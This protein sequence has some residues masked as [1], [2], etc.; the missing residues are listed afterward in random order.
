MRS[1]ED[2]YLAASAYT[3]GCSS[4]GKV[5]TTCFGKTHVEERLGWFMIIQVADIGLIVWICVGVGMKV[6]KQ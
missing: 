4:S 5:E 1:S 6:D 3:K 2:S